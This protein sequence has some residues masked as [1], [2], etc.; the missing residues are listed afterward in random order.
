MVFTVATTLSHSHVPSIRI[1]LVDFHRRRAME[2]Y[3]ALLVKHI[4]DLVS[5]LPGTNVVI[6]NWIF[7][8][9]LNADGTLDHY[10]ARWVLQSFTHCPRV[11]YD[12]TIPIVK[13]ATVWTILSLALSR[14]WVVHQLDVKNVFLHNTLTETVYC[15]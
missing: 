9:K 2:E 15:S 1:V 12:E 7:C 5:C 8:H 13:P 10:K 6:D 4:W 11:D 14:Y 3:E